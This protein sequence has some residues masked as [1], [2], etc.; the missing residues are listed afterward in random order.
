MQQVEQGHGG[1]YASRNGVLCK[2]VGDV[3]CPVVPTDDQSLI[4]IILEDLHASALGGHMGPK[5]MVRLLQKRV[6]WVNMHVDVMKFC[7]Q[8]VNC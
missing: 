4:Q 6:Y 8:C 7:K 1:A 2:L 3:F 5:K